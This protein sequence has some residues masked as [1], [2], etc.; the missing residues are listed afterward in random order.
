MS[1]KHLTILPALAAALLLASCTKDDPAGIPQED[2]IQT[3]IITVTDGGYGSLTR[4]EENGY[5]TKFTEGDACGLYIVRGGTLAYENVK[6]TATA[7][8]ET[9]AWTPAETLT[10][11]LDGESYFLYYPYQGSMTAQIDA[12]ATDDAAFFA[13]L[14]SSWTPAA[15]QSVYATGYTASDLMTAQGTA[16]SAD[17]TVSLAFSTTHRMALAVI[18]MPE[19]TYTFTDN[20]IPDYATLLTADFTSD[21]KPY[22]T[23]DGLYRYIVNPGVTAPTITGSYY[24]ATKGFTVTPSG[25]TS[26][27]YKTYRIN[28]NL[29]ENWDLQASDYLCKDSNDNWYV[30]PGEASPNNECI[31]IVFYVDI[32]RYDDSDYTTQLI[33]DGPVLPADTFHGYVLSLTDVN[34]GSDDCLMWEYGP[35]NEHDKYAG[36]YF[37]NYYWDGYS[38]CLTIHDYVAANDGWEMKHFPAALACETYGKRT[39]DHEGNTITDGRYDWQTSFTAPTNTSGWFLPSLAQLAALYNDKDVLEGSIN[40]VSEIAGTNLKDHIKWFS[41]GIYWSSTESSDYSYS[42][43]TVNFANGVSNTGYEKNKTYYVRA[44][45]VF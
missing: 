8:G 14:I 5:A 38:N 25:I 27:A 31:G 28:D 17:G 30:I 24:D 40:A 16:T 13:S 45:L 33:A 37:T 1:S 10:V 15:D 6:L 21:A 34:N 26:G 22:R 36:I 42:A 19:L 23:T 7:D 20:T 29:K 35:N 9:L 32:H 3:F 18:E 44:I 41:G 12:T 2:G 43:Y 4:A 11:G 39:I